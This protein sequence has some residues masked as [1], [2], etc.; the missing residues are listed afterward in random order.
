MNTDYQVIRIGSL[1]FLRVV[2]LGIE[3]HFPLTDE[4]ASSLP[5]V[6]HVAQ[7][8]QGADLVLHV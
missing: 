1:L 5:N 8:H 3:Y 4:Q 2:H 6:L 7:Y